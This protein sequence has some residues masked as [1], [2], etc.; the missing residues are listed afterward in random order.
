MAFKKIEINRDNEILRL[1]SIEADNKLNTLNK[2]L[3]EASKYTEIRDF[4]AFSGD[5][6]EYVTKAIISSNEAFS[7][8]NIS[9]KKTLELLEVDLSELASIQAE[10]ESNNTS[11][12]F[13]EEGKPF[14]EINEDEYIFF[15]ESPEEN[16][17]IKTIKT[18]MKS[19]EEMEKIT[20]FQKYRLTMMTAGLLYIDMVSNKLKINTN[21]FKNLQI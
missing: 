19:I 6:T 12:F 2:A 11:I 14:T 21:V 3:E 1:K 10:Y 7:G 5:I 18:F 20:P 4:K 17:K 8:L 9:D 13:N 15:T 16:K